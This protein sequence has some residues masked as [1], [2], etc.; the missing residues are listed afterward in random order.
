ML[1][2][3]GEY[4]AI[5]DETPVL[6]AYG[7]KLLREGTIDA[8]F[9]G[10][11]KQHYWNGFE[12]IIRP[13]QNS[14]EGPVRQSNKPSGPAAAEVNKETL[15]SIMETFTTVPCT[16]TPHRTLTRILSGKKN[17][18]D[19]G[20][21]DWATAEAL[22]FGS[23]LR[24]GYGVRLSGEDVERGTFSQRHSVFHDQKTY[25]KWV[26]LNHLGGDQ[27]PYAAYNEPLSEFGVLGFDYGYSLGAQDSLTLWEAQFG[28]FVNNAQVIV[29]QL[30]A[31]GEANGVC[32]P[33]SSCLCLTAMMDKVRNT[34]L[35]GSDAFLSSVTSPRRC[36]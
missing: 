2:S 25:E 17:E 19:A 5:V 27:A 33:V 32:S 1:H 12:D 7:E 28:D 22:A 6:K 21:V 8:S 14:S 24:E 9:L 30:I 10:L 18:F 35:P 11:R 36:F 3:A 20:Y 23:L 29:D 15:G 34:R 26:P 31:S 16:F 13:S 4:R